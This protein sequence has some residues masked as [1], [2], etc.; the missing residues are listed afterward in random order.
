VAAAVMAAGISA[1]P[2]SAAAAAT[3]AD[4]RVLIRLL[5]RASAA[6]GLSLSTRH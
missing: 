2:T 6:I 4:R 5:G 3:S 1:T